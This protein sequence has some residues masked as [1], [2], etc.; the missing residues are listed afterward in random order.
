M[1]YV[2]FIPVR[3]G[4]KG[5]PN[6]NLSE[7]SGYS[8]L[9]WS[10]RS[11]INS[12]LD[13][14]VVSSDSQAY[15]DVAD[16]FQVTT[17]LRS[18]ELATD[19]ALTKDVIIEY[20]LKGN[21]DPV[22]TCVILLQ[23]TCPFR[24]SNLINEGIE[25]LNKNVDSS[26]VSVKDVGGEHPFRM[27]RIENGLLVNYIDQGFEDMRPRQSLPPV[28]LRSGSFYGGKLLNICNYDSLVFDPC[29]PLIETDS[30]NIDTSQDLMFADFYAQAFKKN[31]E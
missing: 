25:L 8:L 30:V 17:H 22:D 20:F 4:S 6:K 29:Q 12:S 13:E 27:K 16:K 2:G 28:Y 5:I 11:A 18:E 26:V 23:A 1:Q 7:I 9:E 15:L 14:V 24:S 19:K 31:P 3:S 21:Y 10:I